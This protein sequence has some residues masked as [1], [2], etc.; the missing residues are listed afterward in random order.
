M[1]VE[2]LDTKVCNRQAS[3]PYAAAL[4]TL[5]PTSVAVTSS[6]RG[7]VQLEFRDV[8]R[9]HVRER[10]EAAR[11]PCNDTVRLSCYLPATTAFPSARAR[12]Q[13]VISICQP[14]PAGTFAV[15][16]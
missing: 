10:T 13:A 2:N 16:Q 1:P 14:A 8:Q 11:P 3:M 15:V 5:N 6:S 7:R 9:F 4:S 12:L